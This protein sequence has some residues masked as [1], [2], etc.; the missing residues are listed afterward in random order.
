MSDSERHFDVERVRADLAAASV[1]S[2]VVVL[3]GRVVFVGLQVFSTM[4]LARLLTPTDFGV[5]ALVL[6]VA[7][8]TNTIASSGLQKAVMYQATLDA[9][10]SSA[11]FRSAAVW[12]LVVSATMALSG[13]G[14]AWLYQD[15]RVIPLAVAW[16]AVIY[17]GSLGAI[18]SGLLKRQM[19]FAATTTIQLA[20]VIVGILVAIATA[21]AG[22]GFWALLLQ[23]A[24]WR[25]TETSLSWLVSGWRP[26]RRTQGRMANGDSA[27]HRYWAGFSGYRLVTWAADQVDRLVVGV[28]G[29]ASVLGLYQTSRRW[30]WYPFSEL[31]KALSDVAVSGLSRIERDGRYRRYVRRALLPL[32]TLALPVTSLVA[33]EA[34]RFV[35]VLL[36]DQWTGAVVYAQLMAVA[37]FFGSLNRVTEWIYF[38]RGDTARQLQWAFVAG[39]VQVA[40]VAIGAS[41]GAVG[42]AVGV[43]AGISLMAVPSVAFAVR[44]TPLSTRDVLSVVARPATAAVLA[45]TVVL[46]LDAALP[47]TG[48]VVFDLLLRAVLH[49]LVYAAVW[50]GLPGGRGAVTEII[51]GLG[52]ARSSAPA[53]TG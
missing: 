17:A 6:P 27:F 51:Q 13:L 46:L 5:M 41:W 14:L 9:E 3:S 16:S 49:G 29:G 45:A 43:T 7:M 28:V 19:R 22:F 48:E 15:D 23:L 12:N 37:A 10:R 25:T 38:S 30:A 44:P 24:A 31:F 26:H 36:G 42:V 52:A 18:P 35:S 39:S 4:V 34:E 47:T 8:L 21:L 2:G 53:A 32:F 1:R 11:Y 33:V 50:F 20:S 40:A